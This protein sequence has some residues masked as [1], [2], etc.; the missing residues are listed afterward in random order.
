MGVFTTDRALVVRS[1]DAWVAEA[2]GIPAEAACGRPLAELFPDIG[3]RGL[4]ERLHRA[5]TNGA[6][7]VLAPAFHHYLLPCT[8]RVPSAHFEQMQQHVRV[9]PLRAGDEIV[10]LS[11]TLEDVT[12]RLEL[13]RDL[14]ERLHSGDE[15]VRLEAAHALARL[16]G[17]TLP[18]AGALGDDSW[19]VRRVVS[20][21][22]ARR[23]AD[24][25]LDV[26][27]AAVRDRHRDPAALNAAI[28]ALVESERDAVAPLLELV[29]SPDADVRTY[30]ALALGQIGDPRAVPALTAALEDADA[31]VRFHAAEALGRIGDRRATGPLVDAATSGDFSLAFAAL[32]ALALIGD[33]A[34]APRLVPLLDDPLLQD[35]IVGALGRLG[36]D[37]HV[38]PLAALLD[39]PGTEVMVVVDALA[40]LHA[41]RER[42]SGDGGRVADVVRSAAGTGAVRRLVEAMDGATEQEAD[43]LALVIGW[44]D[45]DGVEQ[46]LARLLENPGAR[47][48]ASDALARRGNAAV[49][50]LLAALDGADD[51]TRKAVAATLGRIGSATA[52]PALA[53]ELDG[54]AEVAV[55][56]AGA[57]G[58]IGDRQAFEPLLAMLDRPEASVR[59]A[60]VG[61]ISSLGHPEMPARVGALLG[62][63]SPRVRESAAR[64]AG[65]FGYPECLDPMLQLRHDEDEGVRRCVL[66]QL[67]LFDDPRARAALDEALAEGSAA[68]RAAVVRALAHAD[69]DWALPR[70][71]AASRDPDTWVRYYAARSAGHLDAAGAVPALLALA[72]GDLVPPVRIAAVEALG[73]MAAPGGLS[74]LDELA[75]DPDPAV[76]CAAI[77][78]LGR[79]DDP[80]V[81]TR[82]RAT[83]RADDAERQLAALTALSRRDATDVLPELIGLARGAGDARVRDHAVTLLARLDDEKAMDALTQLAADPRRREHVSA[84]LAAHRAPT[85]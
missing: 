38:A 78:A 16:D 32:D 42:G 3:E 66:G 20:S 54:P 69:L 45:G 24:D 28:S 50:P 19:R 43:G 55:V 53:M 81:V 4:L 49:A 82:L 75:L 83:L 57:L 77:L 84:T 60:A 34:A 46:G 9:S 80:T 65:Y 64:I 41:R 15:S 76:A 70:L 51:E 1:W 37:E 36:G 35:A 73:E 26:L 48:T 6:P 33:P 71:L 8:P 17:S 52:G 68:E 72:A 23:R 27:L 47:R 44:L 7:D 12:E 25:A 31:N 30:V 62:H 5:I 11:V 14:A 56:A 40:A 79:L 10:G 67:V 13:E 2:T 18:L 22:L 39:S 85:R 74:L 63:P 61:A 29:S 59:Q 58:T 21:G